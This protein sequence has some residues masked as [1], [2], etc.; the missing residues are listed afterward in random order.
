MNLGFVVATGL[1]RCAR[2]FRKGDARTALSQGQ[3]K[4]SGTLI[5]RDSIDIRDAFKIMI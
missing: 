5:R 4:R 3:L 2:D 1:P